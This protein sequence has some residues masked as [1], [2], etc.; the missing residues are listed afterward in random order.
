[1]SDAPALQR[2]RFADLPIWFWPAVALLVLTAFVL[3][4]EYAKAAGLLGFE[5][6]GFDHQRRVFGFSTFLKTENLVNILNNQS[7]VGIIAIGMTL[8]IIVAGIDLSVGSLVAAAGVACIMVATRTAET[9]GDLAAT[10]LGFAAAL[11]VGAAAGLL[12][13]L[14]VAKGKM[15][16]FVVTLGG[17]AAYRSIALTLAE[18]GEVTFRGDYLQALANGGIPIPGTDLAPRVEAIVP[19]KIL[20][21]ILIFL[22]LAVVFAVVLNRTRLGRY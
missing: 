20:W 2:S 22:A 14:L 8:V 19:L 11:G 3:A 7:Y 10:L 21:P 18:S 16:A 1:M 6:A 13:G 5:P 12:H 4:I 15:A 9:T 17:L